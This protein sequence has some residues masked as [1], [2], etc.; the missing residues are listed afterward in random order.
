MPGTSG[1]WPG[2][3]A[4]SWP[5]FVRPGTDLPVVELV[6]GAGDVTVHQSCTAHMA[7]PPVRAERRTLYTAFGLPPRSP[8]VSA[9]GDDAAPPSAGVA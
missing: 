5:A 2:R 7:R 4:R 6:T 9:T 8:A 1:S 3:T